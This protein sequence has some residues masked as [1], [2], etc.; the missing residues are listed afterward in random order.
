[1]RIPGKYPEHDKLRAI[2]A[3]EKRGVTNFLE[4]LGEQGYEI[5]HGDDDPFHSSRRIEGWLAEFFEIDLKAIDREK[6]QMLDE[7]RSLT[8]PPAE[9]S[10]ALGRSHADDA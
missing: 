6:S 1:M 7:L 9:S 2:D 3:G 8:S 4:W 5:T 10:K